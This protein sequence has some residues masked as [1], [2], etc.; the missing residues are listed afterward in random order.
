LRLL[1]IL[2]IGPEHNSAVHGSPTSSHLGGWAV[3]IKCTDSVTRLIMIKSLLDA[4]FERL[5]IADTFIH[6]DC[7]PEKP[8]AIWLY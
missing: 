1:L 4:G 5:G 6:A 8:A 2:D 3:D 7:D